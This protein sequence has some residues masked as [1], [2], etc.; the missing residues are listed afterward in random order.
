MQII[1]DSLL[2]NVGPLN[3]KQPLPVA[4][5]RDADPFILLHHA[6][7]QPVEPGVFHGRVDPHPHRGFEPVS[8][9]YRGS[10]LHRDSLGNEGSISAGEVQWITSGRGIIHSEGPSEELLRQGGELEIIQLWINLPAAK[11]MMEPAYQEIHRDAIPVV[12]IL[13]D[14]GELRLVAG[15][16]NGVRGPAT[17]QS[18][19][20]AAMGHIAKGASGELTVPAMPT[21]LLYVLGGALRVNGEHIVERHKLVV[22]AELGESISLEAIEPTD[23][24]LLSGKP[25]EEPMVAYGPFVM[26]TEDEIRQ[27]FL[28]FR[29]GAMGRLEE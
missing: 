10:L 16:L 20:M 22:F 1:T 12:K 19:L 13:G 2:T 28:D 24:L 21:L 4:A 3:V 29:Q 27:A 7:P 25:L 26:N 6:G 14:A 17:T 5:L 9:V 23:I 18:P 11:K 15:E 8:F